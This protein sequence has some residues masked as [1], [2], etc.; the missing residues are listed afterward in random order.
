MAFISDIRCYIMSLNLLYKLSH[1]LRGNNLV[2]I[3]CHDYE[4]LFS[5]YV[6]IVLK[7]Y[8]CSCQTNSCQILEYA[9]FNYIHFLFCTFLHLVTFCIFPLQTGNFFGEIEG[10]VMNKLLT[11]GSFKRITLYDYQAMC[12]TN[13]ESSDSAH[14]LLD[15]S[16]VNFMSTFPCTHQRKLLQISHGHSKPII[17]TWNA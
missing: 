2:C 9:S 8:L 12:R 16:T 17:L 7:T 15:V 11:M 5:F 13:K 10:A 3:T 6:A 4:V 14:S 1:L